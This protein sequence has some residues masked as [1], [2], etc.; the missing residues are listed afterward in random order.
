MRWACPKHAHVVEKLEKEGMAYLSDEEA[1][2]LFEASSCPTCQRDLG[3]DPDQ[4]AVQR[5]IDLGSQE[6]RQHLTYEEFRSKPT[7]LS[8]KADALLPGRPAPTYSNLAG[9]ATHGWRLLTKLIQQDAKASTIAEAA[10]SES[11]KLRRMGR[12]IEAIELLMVGLAHVTAH[13]GLERLVLQEW[14]IVASQQRIGSSVEEL[15]TAIRQSA[16]PED[17]MSALIHLV[18]SRQI[19]TSSGATSYGALRSCV[20]ESLDLEVLRAKNLANHAI[21]RDEDWQSRFAEAQSVLARLP[22]DAHRVATEACLAGM[23]A[24]REGQ[25]K[26]ATR[27]QQESSLLHPDRIPGLISRLNAVAAALEIPDFESAEN[28]AHSAW[29]IANDWDLP[30]YRAIAHR[31]MRQVAYRRGDPLTPDEDFLN[32]VIALDVPRELAYAC[33]LEAAIAWRAGERGRVLQLAE[34]ACDFE[35][36]SVTMLL[37]ALAIAS[38]AER[39]PEWTDRL[40]RQ[41]IE[42][43]VPAIGLQVLGLL[44]SRDRSIGARYVPARAWADHLE[45]REI[46]REVLSV[47]EALALLSP[48]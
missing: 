7:K 16:L 42:H 35:G 29:R 48:S 46:R 10:V 3:P 26:E 37:H 17:E 47:E 23:K 38:G 12:L 36:G 27:Y 18:I 21:M 24:Y 25:F 13:T 1:D 32:A 22:L 33:C 4:G 9:E 2:L 19:G 31:Q 39:S 5:P 14:V 41:A 40:V 44:A 6:L 28:I 34:R 43:P 15:L 20:F 8:P 11:E 45:K 30:L